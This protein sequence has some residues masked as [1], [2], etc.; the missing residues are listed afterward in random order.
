MA[1]KTKTNTVGRIKS[2]IVMRLNSRLFLRLLGIY[3]FMDLL[4]SLLSLGGMVVWS[5]HQCA[6]I[7]ALVEERGVPS[8]EATVWMAAGDYTVTALDR[9]PTGFSYPFFEPLPGLEE[10]RHT[11]DF[12]GG[13]SADGLTVERAAY[14]VELWD[15]KGTPYAITLDINGPVRVMTAVLQVMVVCQLIS[16]ICNLFQNAGTIRKTLRPIQEL[17]AAASRLGHPDQMSPEE[18]RVLAGKLDQINATHLD[19]RI[20]VKGTQKEL[21]TLASAINAMLDR[22]NEAYRSQMRFVS[23]AS[24]ELRTPI[25][26]IQGYAN[27]LD[28]WGKD[29]PETRQ[30]AIDA[31]RQEAASMKEL[32]EQLLFLARG[33]NDSMHI[34]LEL[35]DLPEV[36]GEVFRETEMIDKTHIFEGKWSLPVP[37]RADI[38]LTKQ[39]LRILVDNSVKYTPAGGKI[40]LSAGIREGAAILSVQDEGQ[41]MR[42]DD[43]PHIFDRFY[44]TDESRA[45]QTGGTGLGLSIARWIVERHGGWL[46]VASWEGVGTRMTMVLPLDA[47]AE[48]DHPGQKTA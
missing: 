11:I 46:E 1:R 14:T 48:E 13:L 44:R 8:A 39:A 32:V 28:R 22:I 17:A 29:D 45:R 36:A 31:I 40:T 10:A 26:V 18:L 25:A 37:V 12:G 6:D 16:L 20:S 30:E 19:E 47:A 3:V 43:L 21:Q 4:L 7:A 2:S 33:D 27:L 38:G 41:G 5:E 42:A 24:H 35:F 15:S 23:D 34:E 9:P